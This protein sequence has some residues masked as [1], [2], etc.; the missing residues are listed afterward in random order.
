MTMVHIMK[1]EWIDHDVY[2]FSMNLCE[3]MMI[4]GLFL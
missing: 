3:E 2:F 1:L 4:I